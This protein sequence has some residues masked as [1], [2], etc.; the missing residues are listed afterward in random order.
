MHIC[1]LN[2]SCDFL[3][4]P[5]ADNMKILYNPKAST[6]LEWLSQHILKMLLEDTCQDHRLLDTIFFVVHTTSLMQH[7]ELDISIG[8]IERDCHTLDPAL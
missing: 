6:S 5:N 1:I 8:R 7:S 2:Q 3:R 4:G